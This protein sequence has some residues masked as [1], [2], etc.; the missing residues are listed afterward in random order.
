MGQF[1][2]LSLLLLLLIIFLGWG[3]REWRGHLRNLRSIPNRIIVNGTRGKSSVTRLIAAGLR[4]GGFNVMA[5]TTGTKPRII[6]NNETENP[7]VRLGRANIHEQISM[8]KKAVRGKMDTVVFENMSVRPDLQYIEE[9][10]IVQ[11]N[12]VVITNVR[13]D[14]LDVMGPTLNDIVRSFI[15]AVPKNC[16]VV[17]AEKELYDEIKT[18]AAQRSILVEQS[19]EEDV[20]EKEMNNFTYLEHR[21]NVALALAVCRRMGVEEQT[22]RKGIFNSRPDPGALRKYNLVIGGKEAVLYNALAA[23]DPDSTYLIYERLGKPRKNLYVLVNCRDDRIDRSLQMAELLR[24]K[25]PA[26]DYFICGRNTVPLIRH[27]IGR[28]V[29]K[30]KLINLEGASH[31]RIFRTMGER[32]RDRAVIFAIG[33]IVGYGEEL[34]NY[35]VKKGTR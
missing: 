4:A 1:F 17:T 33:N 24:E 32:I 29:E 16:P 3:I 30:D 6:I 5:K 8:I 10:R 31:D 11:P 7:V 2:A 25:I 9:N 13:A 27:A 34:I 20:D 21:E 22:A 15:N 14:H 18:R 19:H 12:L 35:I 23:N 26:D 28:G